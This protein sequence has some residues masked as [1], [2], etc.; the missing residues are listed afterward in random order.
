LLGSAD[1]PNTT[2][3]T[4]STVAGEASA[5]PGRWKGLGPD[6]HS[7][8]LGIGEAGARFVSAAAP[9]RNSTR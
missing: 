1:R 6:A 3:A 2:D 9:G 4:T 8:D 5:T 7:I